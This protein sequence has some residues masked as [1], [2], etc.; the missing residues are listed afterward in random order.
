MEVVT[1]GRRSTE[2]MTHTISVQAADP[3]YSR[4]MACGGTQHLY[5]LG[6]I[7]ISTKEAK[8]KRGQELTGGRRVHTQRSLWVV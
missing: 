4:G 1:L 7:L 8:A 3:V 5:I 6:S 2:N